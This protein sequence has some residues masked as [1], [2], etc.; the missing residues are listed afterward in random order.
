[1][2]SPFV[3]LMA[4]RGGGG[5]PSRPCRSVGMPFVSQEGGGWHPS[6]FLRGSGAT[7]RRLGSAARFLG[8]L[9]LQ[10]IMKIYEIQ[11]F[12]LPSWPP[13]RFRG[14]RKWPASLPSCV[15]LVLASL[16]LP[17][18]PRGVGGGAPSLPCRS[19]G[20]PFVSQ[21][22]RTLLPSWP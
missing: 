19:V 16:L 12:G 8:G 7:A 18:W 11:R 21:E 14:H 17:S 3:T 9:A 1:M 10:R 22:G 4:K 20:I 6:C 15:P 2:W 5:A 13:T